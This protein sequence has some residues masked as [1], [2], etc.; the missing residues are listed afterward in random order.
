MLAV[1]DYSYMGNRRTH[2]LHLAGCDWA[3]KISPRNKEAYQDMDRA[4]KH[5][6][7]GCR[8][9]LPEYSKD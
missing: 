9:C 2:E 8:F 4:W 5:G 6:Y 3:A 7:D 1:G